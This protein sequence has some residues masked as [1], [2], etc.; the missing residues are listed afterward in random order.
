[1]NEIKKVH[2]GRQRFTIAV[3]AERELRAY[4]QDIA[5][6]VGEDRDVIKE[7]EL[8]MAELLAEKNIT[9]EKVVLPEDVTFL[10]EQLGEPGDFKDEARQDEK[11]S[12]GE[13]NVEYDR[14]GIKRLYRDTDN[15]LVAGV[16]SGL[17]AYFKIDALIIRL[18][19]VVLTFT[20]AA[21]II[22]YILLWILVPEAKTPADRL[23]MRGKAVTVDNIK[24]M[25]DRADIPGA[26][27]RIGQTTGLLLRNLAQVARV[28]IGVAVI[29]IASLFFTA[30]MV[31]GAYLLVHGVNVAGERIFPLGTT[32]VVGAVA[33]L[34]LL[35]II[36]LFMLFMG[37]AILRKKWRLPG[38]IVATG[39][40][41]MVMFAAVASAVGID[42]VPK[43]QKRYDKLHVVKTYTLDEF[44][45]A[46][47]KGSDTHFIFK[48][49]KDF[50]V[51]V[52]YYGSQSIDTVLHKEVIEKKLHI[53]VDEYNGTKDCFGFCI[54]AYS[55]LTITVYAPS[56]EEV[57][58]EGD[59][60]F[61]S[62]GILNRQQLKLTVYQESVVYLKDV[63]VTKAL[64]DTSSQDGAYVVT[65]EDLKPIQ[66]QE[67]STIGIGP[68]YGIDILRVQD[69]Q[70]NSLA[71]E[72]CEQTESIVRLQESPAK[73]QI[74]STEALT[75]EALLKLQDDA[76][77]SVYNCIS[78]AIPATNGNL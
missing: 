32:E 7:I 11:K 41:L 67:F 23:Q 56:L 5:A 14:D 4:L 40:G 55:D 64:V 62:D 6:E 75:A 71:G 72:A 74:N 13:K 45:A 37:D 69:L 15:A 46:D 21:G 2:L 17:A 22:A 30:I 31:A 65:L 59:A 43:F 57:T 49:S 28:C 68:E 9:P 73:V 47:L 44:A 48:Q 27:N 70:F 60:R 8:R 24:K 52:A 61:T 3:D 39:V 50:K 25:V 29:T 54:N 76:T 42:S 36:S 34:A 35:V 63:A 51:E 12:K 20:G 38:W 78:I 18:S 16:A 33:A 1:M 10:K 77:N 19:F 58:I 26:A 53:D 66:S